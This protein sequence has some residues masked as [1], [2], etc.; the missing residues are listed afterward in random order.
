[1]SQYVQTAHG[2]LKNV[3]RTPVVKIMNRRL[4]AVGALAALF[5]AAV[6]VPSLIALAVAII[7]VVIE[8]L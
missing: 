5:G 1:M 3:R 8:I 2:S 7:A 4:D 6:V